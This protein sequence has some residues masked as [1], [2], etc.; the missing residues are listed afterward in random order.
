MNDRLSEAAE[1]NEPLQPLA[2][3]DG[4]A[5]SIP[6]LLTA[7]LRAELEAPSTTSV[8]IVA[9]DAVTPVAVPDEPASIVPELPE[10]AEIEPQPL[11]ER[12]A[13]GPE[14]FWQRAVYKATA[15]LVAPKDSWRVRER[16]ALDDRIA[17]P[18]DEAVFVPVVSR[19]GGVGKTTVAVLLGMTIAAVR[20]DRVIAI[21]A[22]PDRGT[23]AERVGDRAPGTVRDVVARAPAVAAGSGWDAYLATDPATGLAVLASDTDPLVA[24]PLEEGDYL[25]VADLV[26]R[27]F[28]VVVTDTGTGV[29][30]HVM[31]GVLSRA[32]VLVIVSGG[33]VEE[34]RLTSETLTWLE[35][36]GR[37]EQVANAVVAINS[38]TPATSVAHLDEI[39]SHF[40]SRVREVVILPYDPQLAAGTVVDFAGLQPETRLAVRELA[41]AVLDGVEDRKGAA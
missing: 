9:K 10:P 16:Q 4:L 14:G 19:K 8:E 40:A 2:E 30:P 31:R 5:G 6:E 36:N 3:P 7:P 25:V 24:T 15:G 20:D 37:A 41:A 33:S 27:D 12:P 18:L 35:A 13:S 1:P 39:T 28:A 38:A 32:D 11:P 21:D 34:A 23:L 17:R 22:N 29:L 26:A